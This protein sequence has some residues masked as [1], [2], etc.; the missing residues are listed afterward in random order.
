MELIKK[1]IYITI[2]LFI[3]AVL[4]TGII[5]IFAQ[6]F[7][8]N[9]A[10][11]S[12]IYKNEQA[13]GSKYIG[14]LFTSDRYFHGRPSAF[15]YNTYNSMKETEALSASGGSNLSISNSIYSENLKN[16]IEKFLND[17]PEL[18]TKEIPIDMVTASGSGVDPNISIQG[19]MI[20]TKRIAKANNIPEEKIIELV[21]NN[22]NN[23]M[24]NV[25][26]LNL[27]LEE[28]LK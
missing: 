26:E 20:Q 5:N 1:S 6:T 3:I 19:A 7:F 4:Y 21:K 9:S 28:L 12:I 16:R 23:N 18:E 10:N 24:I 22:I 27:A 13:I 11:G 17:N 14:Q 2:S 25:L 8:K 15:N